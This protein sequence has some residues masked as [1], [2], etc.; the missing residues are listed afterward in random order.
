VAASD[1]VSASAESSSSAARV[2]ARLAR[3]GFADP[4]TA[5]RLLTSEPLAIWDAQT[6]SAVDDGAAAVLSALG[7]S[8]DPDLAVT[9][10]A[11]LADSECGT[12]ILGELRKSHHYRPRLLGVLGASAALADHL[13]LHPEDALLLR[14]A[15]DELPSVAG[16]QARIL[17]AVGADPERPVTGT[18]G[19]AAELTGPAA[20]TA[21]RKAY[22]TELLI[23]AAQDLAGE[24]GLQQVSESL[25]DLAGSVL[26]AG[27]AVARA[28][29]PADAAPCRL[30]IV[31]MGKTGGR[32]LNYVSDVDVVFVGEMMS[33]EESADAALA[34]ATRLASETMKICGQAA[35]EVDAALRPEGKSGALVRTLASHEAYYK[36]WAST[37]EFQ[38]LL[39]ARPIA[40]DLELGQQYLDVLSPLI[41]TAA[42]RKDFVADVQ[43]MRRRVVSQL[44][45]DVADRELKLGP[46]GLRDVEFAVQL[47]QLV[48]GRADESLRARATLPALAALRDGGFVGRDDAIS[49]ADAYTFLRT[50]EHR[51]Q[52]ARLRRTHLV[53]GS[54][55]A[56]LQLARSMGFRAD[57]RG[58]SAAVWRSEWA[59][60]VREVRRLHEKLFYR[61]LLEAVARVPSQAM[62]L[63]PEEAQRRLVA[64]GYA[65][66]SGALRHLEALTA[67]VSRRAAIQRALLP[68]MLSEFASSPDPDAG[69]LAYRQVSDA[70]G[71]TP[72]FLRLLR[73]EG[74]VA[75]RLAYLLGASRYVAHMLVRAPEAL[76]ML[77]DDAQLQPRRRAEIESTMVISARRQDDLV[78]AAHAIRSIR[79]TELLRIA[80][81]Q[82]LDLLTDS[83]SRIALTELADATLAASLS[84]AAAGLVHELDVSALDIDFAV[85]AMGR[86]GGQELGYSSDAD[87]LYVFDKRQLA[88]GSP[89]AAVG[90]I[91]D[92]EANRRAHLLAERLGSMLSAASTDPPLQLDSNLRPEGR[93]GP[94]VRS[95]SSYAEYYSRWSSLWEAQALLRAR[96]C[97]GAPEL[98][99]RFIELI[100]PI[101]YPEK[102]LDPSGVTEI[103]RIKGRV[104]AERLPRGADPHTHT[105]LGRGGLAD[106][107]WTAQ[108][109]QLRFAHEVPGLRNP[110]TLPAL[111]AAA[112]AGMLSFDQAA[113]LEAAWRLASRARDAITL[114]RDRADDQ[115]P[116]Q[117]L[118]LAAVARV[119]GYQPGADAGQLIDDYRRATRRARR[120]VEAV[121]Y[122]SPF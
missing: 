50:T 86:L 85:I 28:G 122:D 94:L 88:A 120:V 22:R 101:R 109:L 2:S 68:V 12:E 34:T 108:L 60:H 57:S 10:L 62:R 105:K 43:A 77:A 104:D 44:P 89:D 13:L 6:N 27:L 116:T 40:G 65:D 121:F 119:L 106:I 24:I 59:L 25:A 48:H 97:V 69:L 103:R 42:E 93:D 4:V 18:D 107:E 114:V 54:P 41:W 84:S 30:A 52:L 113:A 115:L 83:E 87:V 82:L 110:A 118:L 66:P 64:L 49:L 56:L 95:L 112:E 33:A 15:P 14:G 23:V 38:A 39:K 78:Q 5:G 96:F 35:W 71:T 37:W 19:Q 100:D 79:R 17:R 53:P 26:N 80:F 61:P 72:W 47:L 70:L 99:E 1:G 90:Q 91:S 63:S 9:I 45:A 73:D 8:A 46:G 76:Q 51:I 102:G 98:G 29:L 16:A 32:E 111:W 92:E 117:G 11:L 20:I 7:R 67:G 3:V 81:A 36:R 74:A 31:A 75:S 21:L 58:D 55:V